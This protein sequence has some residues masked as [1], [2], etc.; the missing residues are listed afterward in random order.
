[1][2]DYQKWQN[3]IR[4]DGKTVDFIAKIPKSFWQQIKNA[5]NPLIDPVGK[6]FI[7]DLKENIILPQQLSDPIGD[8]NYSPVKHLVHRYHNR[9][10][11]KVAPRCA[12]YC[13]FCFRKDFLG[14]K[15]Q[16]IDNKDILAGFE[17][18]AQNPVIDEVILS[19]G[20]PLTLSPQKLADI[21]RKLAEIQSVKRLRLHTRVVIV[22]PKDYQELID[23]LL[24]FSRT[25]LLIVHCNH[26]QEFNQLSDKALNYMQKNNISLASQTVLLK[27]I[28]DNPEILANLMND[29]LARGIFPYYLHHLD[30]A[31][32]TE[33]FR[34]SISQGKVIYQK[35]RGLVSGIACPRYVVEIP[36]G[37]G[38]VP[39]MELT[40]DQLS[41]LAKMGIY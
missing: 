4:Q 17:Y 20:D 23:A 33:H 22:D 7:P 12:V 27:G 29:F 32:G 24:Y 10:L 26:S 15:A 41:Q 31:R 40:N 34:I 25:V 8:E 5:N 19:G 16:N 38:K 39:V 1:M 6:Q 3:R 28:N 35:L 37:L 9:V 36:H 14:T 18:I 30:L 21:C 13:R 2:N 11:W